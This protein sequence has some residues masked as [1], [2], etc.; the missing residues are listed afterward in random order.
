MASTSPRWRPTAMQI[1]LALS[2]GV[3]GGLLS[4]RLADP[5]RFNRLFDDLPMQIILVN[6]RSEEAPIE[7]QAAAQVSLAGGGEAEEGRAT[8]PLPSSETDTPG[9]GPD[10]AQHSIAQLQQ[11]QMQLLARVRQELADLAPPDP[12]RTLDASE[13]ARR[14][15]LRRQ[16]LRQ[17]AEIEKRIQEE[18]ARPRKRFIS[19]A[20]REVVYALYY[21]ALR[22]KIEERGTRN[23]PTYQGEKLYG[24]LLMNFTIDATGLVRHVEVVNPSKNPE[25]DRRALA[26]VQTAAPFGPFTEDMLREADEIVVTSR[27]RFTRSDQLETSLGSSDSR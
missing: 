27:F 16:K 9:D 23:F 7:A 15:E 22:R 1:A 8:S 19:P 18:N 6:A 12:T 21:D 3:H 13:Q 5:E 17:L 20:T 10:E 11:M 24:E 14:E 26:I 2:V 25:L 4:L